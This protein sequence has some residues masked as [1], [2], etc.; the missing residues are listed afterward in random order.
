M[1]AELTAESIRACP[2]CIKGLMYTLQFCDDHL[3]LAKAA[4]ETSGVPG[5]Y[6][7][8]RPLFCRNSNHR[9]KCACKPA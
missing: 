6:A 2:H 8:G 1:K 4:A 7:D 3:A 9:F 5:R